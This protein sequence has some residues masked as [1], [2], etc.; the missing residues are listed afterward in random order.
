MY[1]RTKKTKR[2]IH[3]LYLVKC[4]RKFIS[5][6]PSQTTLMYIG[7]A[8]KISKEDLDK[9]MIMAKNKD[10]RIFEFIFEIRKKYRYKRFPKKQPN[11]NKKCIICGFNI[12]THIH[13]IIPVSGGGSSKERN[14]VCLCPN[15]HHMVHKNI[16]TEE[17]LREYINF[18]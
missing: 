2:G 12:V 11:K 14:L 16:I 13:H 3:Y 9:I 8:E 4:N 6:T 18:K 10:K 5:K 1:I 17:K 15:H 7:R